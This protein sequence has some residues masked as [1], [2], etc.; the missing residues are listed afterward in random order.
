MA[1]KK[2]KAAED[3]APPVDTT[4]PASE[5]PPRP[6]PSPDVQAP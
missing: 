4:E 1:A 6:K 2:T 3:K 5:L